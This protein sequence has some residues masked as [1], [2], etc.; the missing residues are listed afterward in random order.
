MVHL[1]T[2]KLTPEQRDRLDAYHH[3]QKQ[4]TY[5]GDI[6]DMSQEL[7]RLLDEQK[8]LQGD[9][10]QKYGALLSDIRESL[11]AIKSRKDPVLPDYAKPVVSAIDDLRKGLSES[12]KRIDVK[13]VIDAP[14]VN[15]TAPDVDLKG[16][17]KA[18]SKLSA[19]FKA[20]VSQLPPPVEIPET[21]FQ[22]LLDS[23]EGISEQLLSIENATR[24]KPLP[25]SMTI[26]HNNQA[27]SSANPLPITG[28][29]T[30]TPGPTDAYEIA[31]SD[32][33]STTKYY[34]FT[35]ADGNWYILREN[36]T[37]GTYR[38][39]KG[40]AA[41]VYPTQWTNRAALNYVYFYE[42]F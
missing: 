26:R 24:M 11:A 13:P 32:T 10:A 5:L 21:D 36:T 41:D 7:I 28:S 2:R 27:V 23:W 3:T 6:A 17:E 39:A 31:D 18:V 1:D 33:V 14:Q 8:D 25:G 16:V 35:D 12:I 42:A 34:G 30:T 40:A 15:V 9:N 4:L 20:A 29:I 22:P 37:N 19:A 38:Y